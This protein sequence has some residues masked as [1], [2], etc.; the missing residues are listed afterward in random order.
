MEGATLESESPTF[1]LPELVPA[2]AAVLSQ[3][4][5]TADAVH[6]RVPC[7]TRIPAYLAP[8][9][10]VGDCRLKIIG[11]GGNGRCSRAWHG[12][13]V[14]SGETNDQHLVISASPRPLDDPAKVVNGPAWYRG[15]RVRPLEAMRINGWRTRAVYVPPGTNEG[16]AFAHHVVLIW[17]AGG[18]T[19]AVGFH[20]V[21]G[22]HETLALDVGFAR[23]IR[24]IPPSRAT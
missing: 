7:P 2:P 4:Q 15:A 16:S 3:C 22:I 5:R 14:G 13:V 17:T 23:G 21:A 10:S 19:Y 1:G 9:E 20:D 24:M 8:T 12:W 18:H 6:Y 11:P